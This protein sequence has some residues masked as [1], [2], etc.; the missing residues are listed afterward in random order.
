V[1]KEA[2]VEQAAANLKTQ[3]SKEKQRLANQSHFGNLS[4]VA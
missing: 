4:T 2:V 3:P 1:G